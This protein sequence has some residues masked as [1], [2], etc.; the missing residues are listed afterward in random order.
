MTPSIEV[1]RK[2]AEVFEVTLDYLATEHDIPDI[3]KDQEMLSRW[4]NLEALSEEDRR[5]ILNVIDAFVRD[6]KARE[7]YKVG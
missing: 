6:A 7:T 1:A 3:L 2:L 5:Q 4:R